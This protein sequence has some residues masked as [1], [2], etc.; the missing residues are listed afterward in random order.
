MIENRIDS[1]R[2]GEEGSSKDSKTLG[3]VENPRHDGVVDEAANGGRGGAM[4]SDEVGYVEGN[5]GA[6]ARH[7]GVHGFW[8]GALVGEA[9]AM[10]H[11]NG[12]V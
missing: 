8:L 9:R 11:M 2:L 1:T 12:G 6:E 10:L 7:V 5:G 4:A 3:N